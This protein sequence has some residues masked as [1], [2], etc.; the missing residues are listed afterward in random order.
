MPYSLSTDIAAQASAV[1]LDHEFYTK[2][3][4]VHAFNLT[5]NF[6]APGVSV[7]DDQVTWVTCRLYPHLAEAPEC[8]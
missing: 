8:A 3:A 7:L 1:G 2:H 5:S 4:N 6:V